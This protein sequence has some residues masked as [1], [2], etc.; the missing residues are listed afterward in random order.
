[1]RHECPTVTITLAAMFVLWATASILC[2]VLANLL[3]MIIPSFIIL[4]NNNLR[5]ARCTKHIYFIPPC[6]GFGQTHLFDFA[7]Y[8]FWTKFTPFVPWNKMGYTNQCRSLY[9]NA[10]DWICAHIWYIYYVLS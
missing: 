3:G 2:K 8:R 10:Y 1:M 6:I 5:Y 4:Q 9:D 7:V